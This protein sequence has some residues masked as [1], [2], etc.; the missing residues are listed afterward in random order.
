MDGSDRDTAVELL[1]TVVQQDPTAVDARVALAKY[2]LERGGEE[3]A[4]R[5]AKEALSR[6]PERLGAYCVLSQIY[7]RRKQ[8]GRTR[9]LVAQGFN[10]HPKAACLQSALGR[11]LLNEGDTSAGLATLERAVAADPQLS[12]AR[13]LI[14]E[15]SMSFKDFQRAITHYRAIAEQAPSS[16]AAWLDL[17]VA[18]KGSGQ[19]EEAEKA[20]RKAAGLEASAA[21]AHFNLGVL[22]LRHLDRLAAAQTEFRQYISLAGA[23]DREAL[24]LLEEAEQLQRFQTAA[25]EESAPTPEMVAT[26]PPAKVTAEP[27]DESPQAPKPAPTAAE[28][29]K[30]ETRNSPIKKPP[31]AKKPVLEVPEPDDFE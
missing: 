5:L 7:A 16:G 18:Y 25:A 20:Y 26:D 21:A 6:A 1:E 11:V 2:R 22:Y 4:E 15:A 8:A 13:F 9:L 29:P 23:D 31:P 12:E 24:A 27:S 10:L 3:E 28:A 17:G 14:A 19:F 30:A